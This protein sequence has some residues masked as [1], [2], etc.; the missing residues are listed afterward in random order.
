MGRRHRRRVEPAVRGPNGVRRAAR[1]VLRDAGRLQ[2]PHPGAHHRRVAGRRRA[3]RTP[4]GAPDPRAAH[5]ARE[6]DE[7][8]LHVAG[9][10]RGHRE[11]VRRVPRPRRPAAHRGAGARPSRLARRGAAAPRLSHRPLDVLRHAVRRGRATGPTADPRRRPRAP[12]QPADDLAHAH[13]H[14]ARRADHPRRS[15]RPRHRLRLERRAP[16][17]GRGPG[18]EAGLGDPGAVTARLAVS[19]APGVPP[20]SLRDR[21]VAVREAARSP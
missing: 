16:L 10:A 12:H 3:D 11:H 21:D 18:R 19:H 15:R 17:H 5:P 2:A 9:A 7:Q 8:R 6:G 20:V 1:G 4:H 13:R 14:R